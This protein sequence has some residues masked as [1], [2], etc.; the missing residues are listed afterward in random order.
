MP[1][2]SRSRK[3]HDDKDADSL[4]RALDALDDV[5]GA[6]VELALAAGLEHQKAAEFLVED[7][8]RLPVSQF[9]LDMGTAPDRGAL[10][11]DTRM[12]FALDPEDAEALAFELL[13]RVREA[14]IDGRAGVEIELD[15]RWIVPRKASSDLR[16]ALRESD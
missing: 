3:A 2:R 13:R 9:S 11:L 5:H 14:E 12:S 10:A 7:G 4:A 15:G 8:D 6:V 1:P 16:R